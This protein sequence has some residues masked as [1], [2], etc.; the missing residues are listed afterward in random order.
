MFVRVV[1][2]KFKSRIRGHFTTSWFICFYFKETKLF[3]KDLVPLVLKLAKTLFFSSF[4][5]KLDAVTVN[6]VSYG[7]D[8]LNSL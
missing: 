6:V 1:F 2:H 8:S 4:L 7:Y 3:V 5:K